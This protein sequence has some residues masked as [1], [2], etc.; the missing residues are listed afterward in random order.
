M[1]V[2]FRLRKRSE[3]AAAD[4]LLLPAPDLAALMSLLARIGTDPLPRVHAVA[5]GFLLVLRRPTAG[6]FPNVV[7]LRRLGSNL[8][9]PVDADLVPPL[10]GDEA[11]ALGRDRGLVFLPG[12]AVLAF[13]PDRPLPPSA[14]VTAP[15]ARPGWQPL[16]ERPALADRV[17]R[18]TLDLPE[19]PDALLEAGGQDIGTEPPRPEDSSLPAKVA[20]RVRL[21]AGQAMMRL[22]QALGLP[23]IGRLGAGMVARALEQVPRLSESLLG[24]Q[25]AA[26]RAL[27][28]MF[29]DGKLEAALRRALPL[30]SDGARGPV[31]GAG[32][33]LPLNNILYSLRTLL[34]GGGGGGR[35]PIWYTSTELFHNLFAEYRKAAQEAARRGDYRR[36]AYIYG[37]LLRDYRAAADAL[38]Q[39]GLYHDAAVV[40]LKKVG[41]KPAAARALERAGEVDEA[42]RLYREL[43][44]HLAAAEA[45][46]RAGEEDEALVEYVLAADQLAA[47]KGH[48]A[49]GELLLGRA[50]CPDLAAGYF[51]TG[52]ERRPSADAVGCALRLARHHAAGA[53]RDRL[54]SLVGEADEFFA[55]PGDDALA[56]Q[57]Y[58]QVAL[59]AG[60]VELR[61]IGDEL[62]DRARRGLSVK[63]RQRAQVEQRP[64]EVVSQTMGQAKV[65]PA[66][67]VGDAQFAFA[68][69]VRHNAER[70]RRDRAA[71]AVSLGA[72]TV[73]AACYAVESGDVFIG[74]ANGD[75]VRHR[76]GAGSFVRFPP[77]TGP[78]LAL[79]TD[80]LGRMVVAL[81]QSGS[82][83]ALCSY[84]EEGPV[85]VPHCW[86]SRP[87][88]EGAWLTPQVLAAGHG[89]YV[90]LYDGEAIQ[91][92]IGPMLQT[93][94]TRERPAD[95]RAALLG[96]PSEGERP[97]ILILG[98]GRVGD[99]GEASLQG[100]LGWTP[101]IPEGSSL[102]VPPLAW[103][104]RSAYE[105]ELAGLSAEGTVYWSLVRLTHEEVRLVALSVSSENGYRAAAIVRPGLVAA[106][107]PSRV[108][109]LRA[110][111]RS[112]AWSTTQLALPRP[113]ACFPCRPTGELI[114]VCGNGTVARMMVPG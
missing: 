77:D 52:W 70:Q 41:D 86:Q 25:E 57:F 113:V 98:A 84:L 51:R 60:R 99:S 23:G 63:L 108:A 79:A 35:G 59:L 36:A 87:L 16:P 93:V 55:P 90:G 2:A 17:R 56:A 10:L 103:H 19:E 14:L 65:W 27:L 54:L 24:R 88:G 6:A 67:L 22:G 18:I 97:T 104:A 37:K 1:K 21:T 71:A 101:E 114:V 28:Q 91:L 72:G 89:R 9:A 80:V 107:G 11:A 68:A 29:R 43:G 53:D 30:N 92:L 46:R 105:V 76:P 40:Y 112:F 96:P 31:P 33:G 45:L 75:I 44:D 13:A 85:Y 42:V 38:F 73:T 74:F 69:A 102:R 26:L 15:V 109:W 8:F 48:L 4:A 5:G 47:T 32:A 20:G 111:S 81:R 58:N 61:E 50:G 66:A 83:G 94:W 49:A 78:V 110:G 39:G 106:V 12:G 100:P 62:K 95:H 64:G 34:G 82:D 3:P 7:R